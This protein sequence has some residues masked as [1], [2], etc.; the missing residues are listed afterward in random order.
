MDGYARQAERMVA[1]LNSLEVRA[2]TAPDGID[3]DARDRATANVRES[4]RRMERGDARP[5]AASAMSLTRLVAD[6]N[7]P[8]ELGNPLLAALT[9]LDRV[10]AEAVGSEIPMLPRVAV[11]ELLEARRPVSRADVQRISDSGVLVP[12]LP[13]AGGVH[14][15]QLRTPDGR[16]IIPAFSDRAL[17]DQWAASAGADRASASVVR[18]RD[19]AAM[20]AD[21]DGITLNPLNEHVFIAADTLTDKSTEPTGNRGKRR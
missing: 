2:A 18:L 7:G 20:L 6:G 5:G 21:R 12:T 3:P 16:V 13:A 17:L 19:L 1:L 14:P 4:A 8:R 15:V 9:E 10:R 11:R